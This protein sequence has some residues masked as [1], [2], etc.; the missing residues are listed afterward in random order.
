MPRPHRPIRVLLTKLGPDSHTIGVTVVAK[1]LRNAGMEVVYTGLE[2]TPERVVNAAIQEDADVVGISSSSAAPLQQLP[3]VAQL[4]REQG[5]GDKL[6][7]AGGAIPAEDVAALEASGIAKTF[8][9]GTPTDE[10]V[11]YVRAWWEADA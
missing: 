1:A 11:A 5:A 9:M 10:I 4:L 3:R 7:I 2:Q 6:V 8:T